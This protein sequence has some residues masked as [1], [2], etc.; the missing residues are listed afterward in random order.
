MFDK[1]IDKSLYEIKNGLAYSKGKPINYENL[2][3][4]ERQE[5]FLA[6]GKDR[7]KA[8]EYETFIV[9]LAESL[10]QED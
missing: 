8:E 1:H 7:I 6:A 10:S 5:R 3:N 9:E 4:K 2:A